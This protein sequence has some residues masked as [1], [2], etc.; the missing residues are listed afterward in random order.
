MSCVI[1]TFQRAAQ[2]IAAAVRGR[3]GDEN[4]ERCDFLFM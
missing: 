4:C 3:A 1:M 2:F